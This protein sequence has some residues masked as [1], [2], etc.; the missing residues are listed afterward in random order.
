MPS[1]GARPSGVVGGFGPDGGGQRLPKEVYLDPGGLHEAINALIGTVEVAE[2]ARTTPTGSGIPNDCSGRGC[3]QLGG[4]TETHPQGAGHHVPPGPARRLGFE[5][6]AGR[7]LPWISARAC[8]CASGLS[9]ACNSSNNSRAASPP[10]AGGSSD[11]GNP[12][13]R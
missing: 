11:N 4:T 5:A 2:K 3:A 1:Q 7:R 10:H 6:D 8:F 12:G 13:S 9:T